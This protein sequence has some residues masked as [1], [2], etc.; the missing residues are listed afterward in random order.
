MRVALAAALIV[1]GCSNSGFR[2]ATAEEA[3]SVAA[4]CGAVLI[5]FDPTVPENQ[6]GLSHRELGLPNVSL[7]IDTQTRA[8]F[9]TKAGCIDREL[10]ALGAFSFI[11]GPNGESLLVDNGRDRIS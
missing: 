10:N 9:S 3:R 5:R 4:K 7:S 11:H 6:D 1:A 2:D 8:E